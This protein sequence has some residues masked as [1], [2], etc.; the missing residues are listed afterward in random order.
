VDLRREVLRLA[1]AAMAAGMD[2]LVCGAP[3]VEAVRAA[4]GPGPLLVVPGIRGAG[5]PVGDQARTATAQE[6]A[7]AGA[8]HLVVGRPILSA[9][10]PAA[11]WRAYQEVLV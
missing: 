2:G 9:G 7:R 1:Q 4:V 10:D 8:T 5:E 3:E 11:A 6:V